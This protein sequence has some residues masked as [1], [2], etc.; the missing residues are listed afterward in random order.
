MLLIDFYILKR[1]NTREVQFCRL[2]CQETV[3]KYV[4]V[5][6][7]LVAYFGGEASIG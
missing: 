5:F 6:A 2:G 7:C 4:A 1:V 3:R